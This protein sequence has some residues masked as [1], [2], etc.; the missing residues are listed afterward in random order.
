M[1][2]MDYSVF[3]CWEEHDHMLLTLPQCSR[4]RQLTDIIDYCLPIF[5]MCNGSFTELV[6]AYYF[7]ITGM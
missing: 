7:A 1:C 4:D 6:R 3:I 5:G 2:I